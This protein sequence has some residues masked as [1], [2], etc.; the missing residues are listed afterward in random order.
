MGRL[1][2]Y[3]RIYHKMMANVGKYTSHDMDG[4]WEKNINLKKLV[5]Q[6]LSKASQLSDIKDTFTICTS[7]Q[8]H[9]SSGYYTPENPTWPSQKICEFKVLYPILSKLKDHIQYCNYRYCEKYRA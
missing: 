4:I 6:C 3:R 7:L 9:D 5:L 2:I 1:Y 8:N